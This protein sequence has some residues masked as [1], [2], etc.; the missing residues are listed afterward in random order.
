MNAYSDK[1]LVSVIVPVYKVEQYLDQ[2]VESIVNQTYKNLQI[3]LV[4]DGSPDGCPQI[5]DKWARKDCRIEVIHQ[6]NR[7]LSVARNS[8]LK[9]AVGGWILFVD[10]DDLLNISLVDLALSTS[11][12]AD[13]VIYDHL[14]AEE[15]DQSVISHTV[16]YVSDTV[17]TISGYQGMM[18]ILR[19]HIPSMAWRYIAKRNLYIENNIQFP[20]GRLLED[21]ATTY[22]LFYFSKTIAI[23]PITLYYYRERQSSIM[24]SSTHE[25]FL[26][27]HWANIKE[28]EK[29]TQTMSRTVRLA[30][31]QCSINNL[32]ICYAI[33]YN[34]D[35][36]RNPNYRYEMKRVC[37]GIIERVKCVG[38]HNMNSHM[39]LKYILFNMHLLHWYFRFRSKW[40]SPGT[41]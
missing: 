7:G 24:V 11:D 40:S 20:V 41:N 18:E 15:F 30:S 38:F 10:S 32:F 28:R 29:F 13:I 35:L 34:Q 16:H 14:R 23:L 9:Q 25:A 1:P 6:E 22:R 17:V 4:D 8:G 31:L 12:G 2:C 39:K 26:S 5:C 27:A 37:E 36:R 21:V 33:L 19:E 3:I